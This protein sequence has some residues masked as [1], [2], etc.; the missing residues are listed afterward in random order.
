MKSN[1]KN[2]EDKENEGWNS[3]VKGGKF[4]VISLKE[5]RRAGKLAARALRKIS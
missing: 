4:P 1:K 3:I 2:K 5:M